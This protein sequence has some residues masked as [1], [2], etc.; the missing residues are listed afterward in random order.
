M[1]APRTFS[2]AALHTLPSFTYTYHRPPQRTSLL[3]GRLLAINA[4]ALWYVTDLRPKTPILFE[5]KPVLESGYLAVWDIRKHAWFD[6]GKIFTPGGVH[7]GYY[8]DVLEPVSW[9]GAALDSL[10]PLTDL[11]L[12]LWLSPSGRFAVL[13]EDEFAEA[14]AQGH[15]TAEQIAG[16]RATCDK[17]VKRARLGTL[18]SPELAAFQLRP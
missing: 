11:F 13:D 6:V 12:D 2:I 1:H 8:A 17:L 7:T 14:V 5:G 18:V 4:R 9:D 15:L 10:A 3:Q 16:A